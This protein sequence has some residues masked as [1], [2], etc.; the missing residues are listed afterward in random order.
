V[1]V[2]P[3]IEADLCGTGIGMLGTGSTANCNSTQLASGG[4]GGGLLGITPNVQL[5]VCGNGVGVLG[6][7]TTAKCNTS[8]SSG[9]PGTNPGSNGAGSSGGGSGA[10]GGTSVLADVVHA[11]STVAAVPGDLARGSLAFTGGNPTLTALLG[12]GLAGAGGVLLR[13][14]RFGYRG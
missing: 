12:L 4:T 8:A 2:S 3:T 9:H 13:L 1:D 14:R 7:G 11:A 5:G 10:A 6:S